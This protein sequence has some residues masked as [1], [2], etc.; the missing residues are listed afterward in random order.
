MN[1]NVASTV[2]LFVSFR[3]FVYLS[4]LRRERPL[5][6][7]L[8]G[9]LKQ[10]NKARSDQSH[11]ARLQT[12]Q[13]HPPFKFPLSQT[14]PVRGKEKTNPINKVLGMPNVNFIISD[15]ITC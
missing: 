13:F 14:M 10:T 6:G 4:R 12:D 3:F 9:N 11:S 5:A 8:G 1:A 7:V 2:F 15:L